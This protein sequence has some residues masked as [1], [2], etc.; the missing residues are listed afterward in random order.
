MA[1]EEFSERCENCI[2]RKINVLQAMS[3]GEL[4]NVSNAKISKSLKKGDTLFKEGERLNG[5]FCIRSGATKLSKLSTNG[6]NQIIKIA[7]KGEVIGKRAIITHGKMHM[8]ATALSDMEVCFIPKEKIVE[9]L[10]NNNKFNL[11]VFKSVTS[12]LKEADNTIMSRSQKSAQQRL[13]EVLL[14]LKS[15]YGVD[16]A[17]FLKLVITREDLASLTG[18]VKESCIRN[19]TAFKKKNHIA[20]DGQNIIILNE[21]ALK[22]II[23]GKRYRN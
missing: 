4:K 12:E 18:T 21:K 3:K 19:M 13:A 23:E 6:N 20:L 15:T 11:E 5:V 14:D 16:D 9:P 2:V 10:K 1:S 17:G 8:E 7:G 22:K